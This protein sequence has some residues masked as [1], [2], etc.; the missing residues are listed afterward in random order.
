M[1]SA[2]L[3]IAE[4]ARQHYDSVFRFC[5][6][7]IGV[8]LAPDVAQDTFLTAQ[9]SLSRFRGDSTLR[10]WLL[11]IALNECRRTL[12]QKKRQPLPITID[13]ASASHEGVS[14]DRQALQT[15]LGNL[16]EEHREVVLMHE[17]DG[18]SYDEIAQIIQVPVGT[19]KSR[20]HHAFANLRRALDPL[21]GGK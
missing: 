17:I 16:T 2:T 18:L 8:D 10:T 19:V 12:R 1:Q 14:V 4:I 5:A 3:D 11:G 13:L 20:L 15:A 9:R 7:R 6:R 21:G